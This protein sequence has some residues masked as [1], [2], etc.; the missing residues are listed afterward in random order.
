VSIDSASANATTNTSRMPIFNHPEAPFVLRAYRMMIGSTRR[1]VLTM[2]T[3]ALTKVL[4]RLL[5]RYWVLDS[6]PLSR[7]SRLASRY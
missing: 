3:T 2:E 5:V 7:S 6:L 4:S 1:N